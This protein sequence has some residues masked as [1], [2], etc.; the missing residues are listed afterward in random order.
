MLEEEFFK[1]SGKHGSAYPSIGSDSAK[2]ETI[3]RPSRIRD[4]T[5]R[6]FIDSNV[7]KNRATVMQLNPASLAR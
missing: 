5:A 6:D 4:I 3:P 2:V 7:L 1:S